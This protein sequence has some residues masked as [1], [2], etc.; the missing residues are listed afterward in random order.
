MSKTLSFQEILKLV[1]FVPSY[2]Q[3]EGQGLWL[4]FGDGGN[5]WFAQGLR[6]FVNQLCGLFAVD[7]QQARQQF[8]PL[9]GQ[10]NLVPLALTPFLIFFPVKVQKPVVSGDPA[11]GYFRLRSVLRLDTESSCILNLEGGHRVTVC[12]SLRKI[13]GHMRAA[14][15]LEAFLIDQL[16]QTLDGKGH[17]LLLEVGQPAGRRR[18]AEEA[19]EDGARKEIL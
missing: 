18:W 1:A 10:V 12:Q 3:G 15:K 11:Y 17:L 9:L 8:G 4:F 19:G 16:C 6:P 2:R 14:K 5:Q 13:R 7:R